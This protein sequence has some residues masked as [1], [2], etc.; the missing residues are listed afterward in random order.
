MN[1]AT[2]KKYLGD[3]VPVA[4]VVATVLSTL[5]AV[6]PGMNVPAADVA[7]VSAVAA[8]LSKAVNWAKAH[9]LAAIAKKPVAALRAA[10]RR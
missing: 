5:A 10:I 7:I 2:L 1:I 3:A 9:G 4:A 8:G 6:L